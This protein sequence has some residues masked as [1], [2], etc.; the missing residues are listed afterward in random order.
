MIESDFFVRAFSRI[1]SI[2]YSSCPRKY[3]RK[4]GHH[5]TIQ[6]AYPFP[7]LGPEKHLT[8]PCTDPLR[9]AQLDSPLL[10]FHTNTW[11]TNSEHNT[12]SINGRIKY[13]H[14]M[15]LIERDKNEKMLSFRCGCNIWS[16]Y[17]LAKVSNISICS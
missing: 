4:R 10:L 16:F 2:P 7:D 9:S 13:S 1:R 12:Q 14:R 5:D 15:R 6:D 17:H 3:T 11:P 8:W